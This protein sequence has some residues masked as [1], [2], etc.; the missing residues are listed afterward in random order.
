MQP[1]RRLPLPRRMPP[2]VLLDTGP[3]SSEDAGWIPCVKMILFLT[4]GLASWAVV[5]LPILRVVAQS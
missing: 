2:E 5:A 4:A 3:V 1:Q